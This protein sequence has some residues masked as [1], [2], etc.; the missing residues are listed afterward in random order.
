MGNVETQNGRV[1]CTKSQYLPELV[2]E[3]LV[4]YIYTLSAI[5]H[6]PLKKFN[7]EK[8]ILHVSITWMLWAGHQPSETH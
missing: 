7:M 8:E 2:V 5:S 4:F 6:C 1:T 3:F